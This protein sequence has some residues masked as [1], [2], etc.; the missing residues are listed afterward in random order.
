MLKA[1]DV[2]RVKNHR[3]TAAFLPAKVEFT[4]PKLC[5]SRAN[6]QLH[7][8]DRIRMLLRATRPCRSPEG[9]LR[10]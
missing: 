10:S 8:R 7:D 6:G 4:S 3:G 2:W 1:T 5:A 9:T